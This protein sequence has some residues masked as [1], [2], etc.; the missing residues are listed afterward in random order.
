VLSV[1]DNITVENGSVVGMPDNGINLQGV[2]ELVEEVHAKFNAN[3]GIVIVQGVVRRSTVVSNGAGGITG[4]GMVAEANTAIGNGGSGFSV[5]G[6]AVI[7]NVSLQN[8]V[9]LSAFNSVYGSNSFN[10]NSA[11]VINGGGATSQNNNNCNGITPVEASEGDQTSNGG[12]DDAGSRSGFY[13][14]GHA[15]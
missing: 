2:G 15:A 8:S 14:P 9:G 13:G 11:N 4:S 5:S 1:N 7:A 6:G 12:R 3:R 10:S